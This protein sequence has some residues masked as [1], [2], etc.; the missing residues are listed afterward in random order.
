MKLPRQK[1]LPFSMFLYV[2]VGGREHS[3]LEQRGHQVLF[4]AGL[5]VIGIVH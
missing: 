2:C 3:F 5:E 4:S 1:S